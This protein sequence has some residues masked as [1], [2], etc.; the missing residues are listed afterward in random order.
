MP[1]A[2]ATISDCAALVHGGKPI[3]LLDVRTAAEFAVVHATGALLIPLNE[4]EPSMIAA[5]NRPPGEA[6]YVLCHSGARA[7]KACQRL[8]DA[9][10][11]DVLCVEGGTTA[12][13]KAGLPVERGSGKVMSMERQVRI[14]AGSLMLLSIVLAWL[15]HPAFIAIGA[16]IGAGLVFSGITDTCGMAAVLAKFP[17]NRASD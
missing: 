12:W 11:K 17:W 13:E 14:A 1:I 3:R 8:T 16:I 4:L 2:T 6:I 9:G 15:I 5:M 10:V 7:A